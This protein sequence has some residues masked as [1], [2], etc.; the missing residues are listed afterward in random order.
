VTALLVVGDLTVEPLADA[1]LDAFVAYRRDP[2]VARFQGWSPDYSVAD[3]RALLDAQ[4][5]WSLPP[6]GEWMQFALRSAEGQLLGDVAVHR[7]DE[8]G[9]FELGVTIAPRN[10]GR[11]LATR[12]LGAVTAH[13][14]SEHGA[15][16]VYAECD[17]RNTGM[18][19]VL[20]RLGF[21]LEHTAE[22]WF[23]DETV[24]V[25]TWSSV[26]E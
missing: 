9:V 14:L 2:D 23:K 11:G 13:L 7:L 16:R 21:R 3:G 24:T 1:D 6:A 15:R 18:R 25:E 5:G 20:S 19:T 17:A 10:Q 12:A 4:R 26:V 8:P 22:E